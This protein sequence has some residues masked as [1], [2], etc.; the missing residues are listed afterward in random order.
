MVSRTSQFLIHSM[1]SSMRDGRYVCVCAHTLIYLFIYFMYIFSISDK[2]IVIENFLHAYLLEVSKIFLL[3]HSRLHTGYHLADRWSPVPIQR[4]KGLY[5]LAFF[6]SKI[7]EQHFDHLNLAVFPHN[8][9]IHWLQKTN[10]HKL[11]S[12]LVHYA[13][14]ILLSLQRLWR[15]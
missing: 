5:D 11:S 3:Q 13:A 7:I 14:F 4:A 6:C 8:T 12:W 9:T 1:Q 2:L 10:P 15:S